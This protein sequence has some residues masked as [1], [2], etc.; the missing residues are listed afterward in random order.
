MSDER[1]C[2]FVHSRQCYVEVDNIPLDVCQLCVEA[3]RID[4]ELT[5]RETQYTNINQVQTNRLPQLQTTTQPTYTEQQKPP[6]VNDKLRQLDQ[7]FLED[8]IDPQEYVSRR[9]SLLNGTQHEAETQEPIPASPIDAVMHNIRV[10]VVEKKL[11]TYNADKLPG[12]WEQPEFMTNKFYAN[13]F[14]LMESLPEKQKVTL[15]IQNTKVAVLSYN[16]TSMTLLILEE[17]ESV[18]AVRNE[19]L[20]IS[21]NF[22]VEQI[23]EALRTDKASSKPLSK[24][25][26]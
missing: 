3:W 8:T 20:K 11:G 18:E 21:P 17:E 6:D 1:R 2:A 23:G 19:I 14:Q 4:R 10:M 7:L 9:T 26:P 13:L 12:D 16:E 25:L 15:Q 22:D 24:P 5:A